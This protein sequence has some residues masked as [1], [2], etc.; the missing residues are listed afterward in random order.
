MARRTASLALCVMAVWL[1]A[2]TAF[3]QKSVSVLGLMSEDGD[4]ELAAKLTSAVRRQASREPGWHVA[5]SGPSLSQLS[6]AFDCELRSP[7][8]LREMTANLGMDLIV[9]GTLHREGA[10]VDVEVG[11]FDVYATRSLTLAHASVAIDSEAAE[12]QRA[13]A[14]LVAGLLGREAPADAPGSATAALGVPAETEP[15]PTA[16]PLADDEPRESRSSGN[17]TARWVGFSLLGVAGVSAVMTVV[18]WALVGSATGDE[19]FKE[20]RYAIGA[21][22]LPVE[23]SC[24]E[25]DAGR[26]YGLSASDFAE[27][28]DVCAKGKTWQTLQYVF[29]GTALATGAAGAIVLLTQG[30]GDKASAHARAG[31]L[32]LWPAFDRR[33]GSLTA[34]LRF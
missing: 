2:T 17:N 30:G 22:D 14:V 20:Y 3:A 15:E 5:P 6:M 1:C 25:A 21:T 31:R 13:A 16:P 34:R 11:L 33:G 8:C 28:Q 27:V 24:V 4:D 23:D 18:S 19:T 7:K 10:A 26:D 9:Y 32:A 12:L 29:L